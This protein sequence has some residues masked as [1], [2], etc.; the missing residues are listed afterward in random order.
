MVDVLAISFNLCCYVPHTFVQILRAF[1]DDDAG[2][3]MVYGKKV[4]L[5]F[6]LIR[7]CLI[8]VML[9]FF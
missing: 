7:H 2:C 3:Y 1:E 5:V 8:L 9:L 6:V 4:S